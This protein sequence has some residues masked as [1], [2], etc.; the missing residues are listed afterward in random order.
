M[1]NNQKSSSRDKRGGLPAKSHSQSPQHS[2]RTARVAALVRQVVAELLIH[3]VKDPRVKD[4]SIL[5][6]EVTPDLREARIFYVVSG[7][8]AHRKET[9]RGLDQAAGFMQRELGNR[10]ELRVTPKLSFRFDQS[11]EYGQKI[12]QK[13]REL[14]LGGETEKS[15]KTT[16]QDETEEDE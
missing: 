11:I 8:E 16:D 15:Q 7:N 9:Q 14:G 5:D 6:A 13:L 10:I 12:E 2:L 3:E 1:S 4:V